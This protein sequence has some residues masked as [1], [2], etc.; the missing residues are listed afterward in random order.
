MDMIT[1]SEGLQKRMKEINAAGSDDLVA[2]GKALSTMREIIS[3]LKQFTVRYKFV[4]DQ[5]EVQF[6]KE[7]K[8][9]LLSQYYY[10]KK[11]FEILLFDSF[12]DRKSRMENYFKIMRKLQQFAYKN[13]AFYEY[14]MSGSS[15]LDIQYFTRHTARYMPVGTDETFSTV[16]DVKLA[17]ILSHTLLKDYILHAVRQTEFSTKDSPSQVLQW[18]SQ[19]VALVEL[20]YALHA[21]GVF[22]YGKADLK[23]IVNVFE[24]MFSVDLGNYARVFSE[25][26]IRKSG[27]AN[28]LKLLT[29]RLLEQVE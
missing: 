8:P 9:V 12:R 27:Q 16:Y 22:N 5:E 7:I 24:E 13:E 20:I 14:C 3:E 18:T 29:E 11:K 17:K 28:F 19:K 23:Q 15:Y 6:F 10:Y 21:T 4:N 25:I 1:F 2:M 26:R